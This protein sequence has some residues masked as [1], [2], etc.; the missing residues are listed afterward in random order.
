MER[1]ITTIPALP[2]SSNQMLIA[3]QIQTT[4]L[5]HIG[6]R[7]KNVTLSDNSNYTRCLYQISDDY[8]SHH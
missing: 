7:D 2:H 4:V 6:V 3:Y 5:N 8:S 1:A